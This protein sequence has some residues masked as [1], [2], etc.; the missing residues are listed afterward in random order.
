MVFQTVKN[1]AFRIKGRFCSY[2]LYSRIY[3]TLWRE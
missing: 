1:S 3:S 2:T